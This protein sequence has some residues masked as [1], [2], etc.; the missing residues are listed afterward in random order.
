MPAPEIEIIVTTDGAEILRKTVPPGNYT[1]GREPECD[2]QLDV[3]LVSRRHAQLT[4]QFDQAWIEDLGSSNGTFVNGQ[5][6][7][8]PTRLWPNQRIQIG[9]ASIELRR[10]KAAG[11]PDDSLAGQAE[12]VERL[13]PDEFLSDKK[14]DIGRVIAQGGMGMILDAREAT[15]ERRVAMKVMLDGSSPGDLSR[16]IAEAK[17]TGQLEH[18]NV[19]PVHELGIDENG[20]PFYTMKMVRGIT[21][22][23]VLGLLAEGVP[24]TVKKYPLSTLLT[25]FQKVCDALAFAH[26]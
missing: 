26:S 7:T 3:D 21:L 16:F 14:Y 17:I 10:L 4:V 22:L 13:L 23:K 12:T 9:S 25:I 8:E 2:I 5:T 24:E 11:P 18:P 15:I 1:I 19:I 20:Q 6:V